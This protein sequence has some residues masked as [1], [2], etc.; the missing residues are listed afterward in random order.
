[1]DEELQFVPV[2]P[3]FAPVRLHALLLLASE[4]FER[5]MSRKHLLLKRERRRT[6]RRRR[7]RRGWG[8]GICRGG[9]GREV[10]VC[11]G[12]GARRK[13]ING[14]VDLC[15][16]PAYVSICQHTSAYC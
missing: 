13:V 5:F 8:W 9:G 15:L 14:N 12:V 3:Q 11:G 16:A 2:H 7:R 10:C 4:T 1:V 6:V